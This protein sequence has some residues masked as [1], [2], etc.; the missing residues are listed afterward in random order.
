MTWRAVRDYHPINQRDQLGPGSYFIL[1]TDGRAFRGD[2]AD[3][4]VLATI[5]DQNISAIDRS[6]GRV[7]Y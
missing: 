2:A 3:L 6:S 1:D 4:N 7:D 5:T